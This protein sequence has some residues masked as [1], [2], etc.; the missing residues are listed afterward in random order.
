MDNKEYR[1]NQKV[2]RKSFKEYRKHMI[3]GLM[4]FGL[5]IVSISFLPEYVFP[6]VNNFLKGFMSEYLAGS[7]TVFTQL[8]CLVGG[9]ASGV[10]NA[11]KAINDKDTIDKAQDRE[12]E[13]VE[14]LFEEKDK[15]AV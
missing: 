6:H 4:G 14:E 1:E 8:A 12:E 11:F 7:V 3:R 13:I 9:V 15:L 10:I 5:A 2:Q